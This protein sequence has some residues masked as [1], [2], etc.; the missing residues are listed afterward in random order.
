MVCKR[1]GPSGDFLDHWVDALLANLIPIGLMNFMIY[2][3]YFTLAMTVVVAMAFWSNNWETKTHNSRKLPFL[4]GLEFIW[5]GVFCLIATAIWGKALWDIELLT[6]ELRHW[7]YI[8]VISTLSLSIVK[9]VYRGKER[10]IEILTPLASFSGIALFL[11]L[12]HEAGQTNWFVHYFGLMIIG[13]M[14][15][16]HTGDQMSQLWLAEEP[17]KYDLY[18]VIPAFVL[19]GMYLLK[20]QAPDLAKAVTPFLFAI[21]LFCIWRLCFQSVRTFT[22]LIERYQNP[23]ATKATNPAKRIMVDM[24]ATLLHHGH[25]RL[26]KQAKELGHVVVGLTSDADL[27]SV[28]NLHSELNFEERREILL[29]LNT[30]DEVVETPWLLTNAVL[31]QHNI[32]FLVH[33]DD[34]QNQIAAEKLIL[35]PRTDGVSSEQL[36]KRAAD[37]IQ[38]QIQ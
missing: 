12:H 8:I 22:L 32:D 27:K 5:V 2:D 3:F 28:K 35:F 34:N 18:F 13:L 37:N 25:I 24:S 17:K 26:L 20:D 21:T 14:G 19:A 6:I 38:T 36:R 30:V 10:V 1:G 31:E 9:N 33:G 16:K 23:E 11:I 29:A 7:A 15:V 4:G